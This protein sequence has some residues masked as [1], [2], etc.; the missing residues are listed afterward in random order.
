[1]SNIRQMEKFTIKRVKGFT[2]IEIIIVMAVVAILLAAIIPA[3]Q[4]MQEEGA[5]SKA[6]AELQTLKTAVISYKRHNGTYPANIAAALTGAS[7]KILTEILEDPFATDTTTTPNTYGYITG[8]DASFGEYF[9][10]YSKGIDLTVSTAWSGANDRAEI[11]AGKDDM[12]VSNAEV[13]KL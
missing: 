3:F 6:E 1:M 9:I 7:P 10:I 2:L 11:A 4:G 13:E 8:T 12:A 5:L